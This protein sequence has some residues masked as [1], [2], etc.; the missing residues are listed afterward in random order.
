MSTSPS[1]SPG[2][3]AAYGS[4]LL[5]PEEQGSRRLRVRVQLLLTV[6]LVATNVIGAGVVFVLS[7]LVIPGPSANS[8]TVLSLAIGVPVYVAAALAVG[9]VWG[10]AGALRALRWA[11]RDEVPTREQRIGALGVPWFLTKVQ[12]TLWAT[13]TVLFTGLAVV[14]QPE[15]AL[16]TGLTVGIASVVVTAIAYLFTEFALRPI[17]ARALAGEEPVRT[18]RLGVRRRMVLFWG[19]GTGA[20]V[21]GLIVVSLLALSGLEDDLGATRLAVIMLVLG[22]V[23]L[24]FGLLVTWLNARAVVAPILAVR[25]AMQ[26][27]ERGELDQAVTVYDGTELGQLQVG[28]NQMVSGLREREHLRDMFG[29]HVGKEVAAAAARGDVELGGE[30][31]VVSVLFVDIVGSTTL[32]SEREPAEV[33]EL[34]NRFFSVVVAEVAAREGLV[35]KFIGDAALAVFGAPVEM[36]DHA[37]RALAT[38]RAMAARLAEEVPELDAGI[39][40]AT[41]EAVAGNVGE[42]SRFEYTVIGDAVNAA[43]RLTELAKDVEGRVLVATATVDDA[44]KDEAR[45][46]TAYDAVTLRGR[47]TETACSVLAR[48]GVRAG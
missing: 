47:A 15:R 36:P 16:S 17:A 28:F 9:V 22:S 48:G 10:T 27:V 46:W 3:A 8:G 37:A 34:L 7:A 26:R 32:A 38:A 4:V 23:V 1:G 33:V 44:G 5:G 6:L 35:N 2:D 45:H 41:G 43:A 12:A 24:A 42:E 25:D 13:A 14:V 30:T 20:P 40:V 19:L 39:G 18:G 31:R 11:Y 29:R 21:V